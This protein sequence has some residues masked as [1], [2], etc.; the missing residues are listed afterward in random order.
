MR[1]KGVVQ[2]GEYGSALVLRYHKASR[3]AVTIVGKVLEIKE[4]Y[5]GRQLHLFPEECLWNNSCRKGESRNIVQ[6][7]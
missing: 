6:E 3:N 5:S 7:L 2:I 4:S 1:S